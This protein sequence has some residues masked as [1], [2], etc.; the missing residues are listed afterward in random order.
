[1]NSHLGICCEITLGW[2]Q[3]SLSN[4]K[5][6]LDQVVLR[7]ISQQAIVCDNIKSALCQHMASLGHNKLIRDWLE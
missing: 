6:T 4:E 7:A 2:M 3:Q 5:S 1:M